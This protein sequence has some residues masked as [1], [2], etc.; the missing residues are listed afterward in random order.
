MPE[1]IQGEKESMKTTKLIS[2]Q[3]F[4]T[5]SRVVV[6]I[7]VYTDVVLWIQRRGPICT[8]YLGRN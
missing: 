5:R 3:Q 8:A 6:V 1:K 4:A 2:G 7:L